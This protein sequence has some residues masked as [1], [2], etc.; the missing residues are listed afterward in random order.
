[1]TLGEK[2]KI[3][4]NQAGLSQEQLA[5]K[6]GISRSA[7]AKWEVNNGMPD[8]DNLK[9]LSNLLGVTVDHLIN[10]SENFE[11]ATIKE[12]IDLSQY[13]GSKREKKD[14][15]VREK[16]PSAMIH[17]LIAKQKMKKGEKTAS[18]LIGWLTDAPFGTAEFYRDI[19][20]ADNQYYLVEQQ[21]KQFLVCVTSKFIISSELAINQYGKKFE[22]GNIKF[23][24][25]TYEVRERHKK[26]Y[27]TIRKINS[28]MWGIAL[29]AVGVIFA[30][31]ALNIT[32]VTLFFEGWW[33]LFIIVPCVIGLFTEREKTGNII[34]LII[35]VFLFLCCQDILSFSMLWKLLV[36]AI[37]VIIGLKMIFTG[38]FSNKANE[39]FAKIKASGGETKTGSAIFSGQ[40]INY[41]GQV[42]E[43]AELSAIFGGVECNLRNAIIEKDC[44]IKIEAI[45]GGIDI[46]VPD[47]INVKVTS[48]CIFG[49]IS[50]KT[51]ARKEVP[52]L[53]IT[54]TCVFGG[55]DIK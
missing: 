25:C 53:Y 54:G 47:N 5:E 51:P 13:E 9:M 12:E 35:G 22:I 44:A 29:I 1:M 16:Y 32:D 26:G 42:F 19:Q 52:T 20:N 36:P 50:N 43:G 31:N 14:A 30:L 7:V 37:I 15:V 28:V 6:M 41:D 23:T 39:I 21:G 18:E 8:I 38:L 11:K 17:P 27:N 3:A 46:F 2:I 34:G 49:G 48:N 4:R 33:T 55:V 10:D 45:F 24:K 40:D